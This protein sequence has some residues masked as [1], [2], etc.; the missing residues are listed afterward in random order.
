MVI[1]VT[2]TDSKVILVK[3]ALSFHAPVVLGELTTPLYK[4]R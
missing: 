3:Y 4:L 2:P 1:S